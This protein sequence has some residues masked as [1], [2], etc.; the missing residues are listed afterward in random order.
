MKDDWGLKYFG[1]DALFDRE[2]RAKL[3]T[4]GIAKAIWESA[5]DGL[6]E[7]DSP[8]WQSYTG[9]SYDDW[10]GYGWLTAI[11]PEDRLTT[12]Q[13]WRN[14]VQD[15]R[16]IDAEYRL[17]RR[18]GKYRW[19]YVYAVPFRDEHGTIVKWFGINIDIHESKE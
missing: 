14:T 8:S 2:K 10:K 13:K 12:V 15:Q 19:M 4:D 1:D 9:Q 7:V 17:R 3:L 18:D 5:P 6:I 11:H 16:A